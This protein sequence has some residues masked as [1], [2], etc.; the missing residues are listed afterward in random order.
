M[1][2]SKRP[3]KGNIPSPLT[4]K[5][6]QTL[7]I[8]KDL[9]KQPDSKYVLITGVGTSRP[10]YYAI[11]N[12]AAGSTIIEFYRAGELIYVCRIREGTWAI[13]ARSAVGFCTERDLVEF[14]RK[15]AAAQDKFMREL[16]PE[17]YKAAMEEAEQRSKSPF[18]IMMPQGGHEH[19]DGSHAR[20]GGKDDQRPVPGQYL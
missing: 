2:P 12:Y 9:S 10:I 5:L 15:D 11:D 13:L 1:S 7:V 18:S 16:D 19:G 17:G 4:P 20:A 6:D 14:T 8:G 3:G